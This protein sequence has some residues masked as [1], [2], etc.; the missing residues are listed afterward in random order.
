MPMQLPLTVLFF[1]G[2]VLHEVSHVIAC[3]V[4]GV[5][6]HKVKWFGVTEAFVQHDK[7]RAL[8]GL[9]ISLAPL[10]INNVLGFFLL[11]HANES[12]SADPFAAILFAWAG[13]SLVIFSFPSK[14]DAENT[15]NAFVESFG[16]KLSGQTPLLVRL[17]WLVLT[18]FVFIPLILLLGIVL[19]FDYVFVFR[20]AW[21]LAVLAAVVA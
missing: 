7:P 17:V 18:P 20:V 19:V 6:V 9:V 16:K 13:V 10:I 8:S 5:K 14:P 1:P 3:A 21:L 15:F 12:V 4:T 2:V 11:R